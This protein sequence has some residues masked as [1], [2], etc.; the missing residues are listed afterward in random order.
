M[1]ICQRI[2]FSDDIR[3]IVVRWLEGAMSRREALA[4]FRK[5]VERDGDRTPANKPLDRLK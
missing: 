5:F 4:L 2:E 1:R 3:G